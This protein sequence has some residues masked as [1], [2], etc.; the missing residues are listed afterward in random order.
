ML[1]VGDEGQDDD[2]RDCENETNFLMW[3]KMLVVEGQSKAG[4]ECNIPLA[5]AGRDGD[6]DIEHGIR[7]GYPCKIVEEA[8]VEDET[9]L[10]FEIE[11]DSSEL[12]G[13][14]EITERDDRDKRV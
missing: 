9:F 12:R 5:N 6:W 14:G 13:G 4:G 10:F 3:A 1:F 7:K 2:G 11:H 8:H